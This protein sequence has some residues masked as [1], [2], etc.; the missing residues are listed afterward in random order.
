MVFCHEM[1]FLIVSV[2]LLYYFFCFKKSCG[3]ALSWCSLSFVF[4]ERQKVWTSTQCYSASAAYVFSGKSFG[5]FSPASKWH[6]KIRVKFWTGWVLR[7]WVV[8]QKSHS[9]VRRGKGKQSL[10]G[11]KQNKPV[12]VVLQA[13]PC[14]LLSHYIY[15]TRKLRL[16]RFEIIQVVIFINFLVLLDLVLYISRDFFYPQGVGGLY[17]YD[18]V[19]ENYEENMLFSWSFVVSN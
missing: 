16:S 10:G 17:H 7:R 11:L 12:S 14:E 9:G 15:I 19:K 5:A 3:I 18:C 6:E 8:E 1:C 13:H 4:N 2:S